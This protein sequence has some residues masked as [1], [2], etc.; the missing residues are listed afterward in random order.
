[1]VHQ[2]QNQK[3][4][5][6]SE[7]IN[8]YIVGI[9]NSQD[10]PLDRMKPLITK[11]NKDRE[12]LTDR[13]G[14]RKLT[15]NSFIPMK[16]RDSMKG[17]LITSNRLPN[18][19]SKIRFGNTIDL[20]QI[21]E[22]DK[23]KNDI[24]NERI[25]KSHIPTLRIEKDPIRSLRVEKDPIPNLSIQ[26]ILLRVET[27]TGSSIED[28]EKNQ[29]FGRKNIGKKFKG[30]SI[31]IKTET[32]KLKDRITEISRKMK[33]ILKIEIEAIFGKRTTI[34]QKIEG[35]IAKMIKGQKESIKKEMKL[36]DR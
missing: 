21:K 10:T 3:Y 12:N 18:A 32:M 1:M 2:V 35:I 29:I 27:L 16:K 28:R 5:I 9:F 24:N 22:K 4:V 8:A 6:P 26:I 31:T 30:T 23:I 36:E 34:T 33:D 17:S 14:K 15:R 25:E 7:T 13:G 20:N 11:K 19:N